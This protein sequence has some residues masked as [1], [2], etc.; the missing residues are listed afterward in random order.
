MGQEKLHQTTFYCER[1]RWFCYVRF[2][3]QCFCTEGKESS[4]IWK[5]YYQKWC[6]SCNGTP[7]LQVKGKQWSSKVKPEQQNQS[8]QVNNLEARTKA[9]GRTT[10]QSPAIVK[11]VEP[12]PKKVE[13]T[14][15]QTVEKEENP[16]LGSGG[17]VVNVIR[18]ICRNFV[19]SNTKTN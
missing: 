3:I 5:T 10:N 2:H 14:L 1:K 15:P 7:D 13:N 12:A 17:A 8:N 6:V 19:L 16:I 9:K 4:G 18:W 11:A